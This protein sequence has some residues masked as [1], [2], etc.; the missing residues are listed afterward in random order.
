MVLHRRNF[1]SKAAGL[2]A[3]AGLAGLAGCSSSCPDHGRPTASETLPFDAPPTGPFEQDPAGTWPAE[4]GDGA[5][6]GF[7]THD[8]PE[9]PLSVRWGTQLDIP[10]EDG[11][12]VVASAPVVGTD[13]VYVADPER[14]HALSLR[15]GT[16][17]WQS[18]RL[19]VTE[20][21]RYGT[22]RPETIAPRIG[23]EGRVFIG[24][25]TGLAALDPVEGSVLWRVDGLSAAGPPTVAD[26]LVIAHGS[27]TVRA[28]DPGGTER[29]DA[30]V[31]RDTSRRQ[32]AATSDVVV[33]N[34]ETGLEARDTETGAQRWSRSIQT[35]SRPAL[36][37]GT[38]YVG[39]DEGLRGI[40]LDA[41]TDRFSYMRG[42]YMSIQSLV[43][44]PETIYV[45][46]QPPEAGAASFALSR[47]DTGVEP[48]WCSA[49]GDGEVTAATDEQA[50]GM[51]ALGDGP[52]ATR[53]VAGFTAAA[54]AVH[55]ALTSGSRSDTWLNPPAL[56]D[57]VLVLTTRGGRTVA[58]SGGG[59]E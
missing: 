17:E 42:E 41:G 14:V 52:S 58:V 21:E 38:C 46:E 40:D 47:T 45:V 12:G 4:T 15:T 53:S 27:D 11:V 16:V 2:L 36:D 50:L 39:T 13:R 9:P 20:T 24:L 30:T 3:T 22:Y 51:F 56:L 23:P 59:D 33:L 35:E 10:A 37:A 1:L 49:I 7:S 57:D 29:W 54:G 31:R 5:N 6:T 55:W 48:R 8:L 25:E 34:T 19:P 28:F 44:T 43:V 18:D 26:D 32:P